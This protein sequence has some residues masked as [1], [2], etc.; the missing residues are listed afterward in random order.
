VK[1]IA[2]ILPSAPAA[3][4]AREEAMLAQWYPSLPKLFQLAPSSVE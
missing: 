3:H 2:A 4:A 1:V